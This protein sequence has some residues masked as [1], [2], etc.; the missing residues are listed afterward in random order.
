MEY[1]A[2]EISEVGGPFERKVL[3]HCSCFGSTHWK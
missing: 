3:L 1:E 2:R